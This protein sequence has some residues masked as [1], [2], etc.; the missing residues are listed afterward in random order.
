MITIQSNSLLE[1]F[2]FT[3]VAQQSRGSVWYQCGKTTIMASVAIEE[4]VVVDEDFLPLTVQYI[5]R[6]YANAKFPSGF[7]K[8]EGK[9]SEFEILTSR[10][11]DRT[12]RPLFPDDY[13][14]STQITVMVFSYDGTQDLQVCALNA[15]SSALYVAGVSIE[16]PAYAVR[17]GRN[18]QG[19][20]LNPN[21]QELQSGSLDLYVSGCNQNLLMIEMRSLGDTSDNCAL[22]EEELCEAIELAKQAIAEGSQKYHHAFTSLQKAPLEIQKTSKPNFETIC[23][24]IQE[25]YADA[26]K[27]AIVQMAKSERMV[28]I[29]KLLKVIMEKQQNDWTQEEVFEALCHKKREMMREMILGDGIR[30]DLRKLNEV[31]PITIETNLLPNAHG[32]CLFKRG[33]TQALVVATIGGE[34]DAQVYELL[35]EKTPSK[36]RLMVH[37]NFPG[38]SVGEASMVG[39]VGRRE[40]GHGNL[41]KRALESS[42]RDKR[43]VRLVSEILESNGS[44]SMATVCGGSLALRASGVAIQELVAGVAM[45]LI[46]DRDRYAILTD[47]MGLEDHEGDM[48]FKIAGTSAGVTAMQMDIKLGGVTS[49]I[50][51]E[52]LYQ[53][54]EARMQILAIMREAEEKI[55]INEEIVPT[56]ISFGVDADR[57]VDIIGQGGKTI[58]EIIEKFAVMIDLDRQNGK[59]QIN[60][61]GAERLNACKDYILNF[62]QQRHG[63]AKVNYK[64]YTSGSIFEGRVKKL[65]EFGAFVELPNGGDGLLHISKIRAK[66]VVL[67]EGQTIE[68][69]ILNVEQNKVELDF[70]E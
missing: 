54:K 31:R 51:K 35:G 68:C 48:D 5:E 65:V 25:H 6:A 4:N 34:Q 43:V 62:L 20:I 60:G 26:L 18:Q 64:A 3:K 7:I 17:V 57:I 22:S 61:I 30:A 15:A 70:S 38:F 16:S 46:K 2:D 44:S 45:G 50:L 23:A 32:S 8:R 33:Q 21:M 39:A 36:E 63:Q 56:S 69:K 49:N 27:Q 19:L 41:A 67:S 12:L 47:I 52:A 55:I 40:L 13:R 29:E 9:P 28:E 53:A 37:Y 10:I 42:V 14:Y 66:G 1:E 59:V 11:I 58:K 24:Y